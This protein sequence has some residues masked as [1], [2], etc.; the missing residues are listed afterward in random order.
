MPR[1]QWID[2]FN[3]RHLLESIGNIPHTEAEATYYASLT[4]SAMAA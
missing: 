4:P 2:R 1:S 3:N